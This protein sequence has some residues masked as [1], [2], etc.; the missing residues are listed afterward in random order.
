MTNSEI[1]ATNMALLLASGAIKEGEEINYITR[2]NKRG[3]KVKKGAEHIAKFPIWM[4][5]TKEEIEKEQ[6]KADGKTVNRFKLVSTCWFSSSQV[7]P[8]PKKD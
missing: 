4:P 6:E 2:W 3:F 7:E 1:V 8:M 5:K